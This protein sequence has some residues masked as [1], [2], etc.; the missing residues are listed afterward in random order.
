MWH[1]STTPATTNATLV[2]VL[3]GSHDQRTGGMSATL[4]PFH[5][6]FGHAARDC[7][8]DSQPAAAAIKKAQQ[9]SARTGTRQNGMVGVRQ[10]SVVRY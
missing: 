8:E 9:K 3:I 6:M 5:V 2:H 7:K 1:D 4:V 10:E